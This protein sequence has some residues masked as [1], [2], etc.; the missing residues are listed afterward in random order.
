LSSYTHLQ[1]EASSS[2]SMTLFS[3]THKEF[4]QKTPIYQ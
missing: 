1:K 3:L 2:Q 4:F